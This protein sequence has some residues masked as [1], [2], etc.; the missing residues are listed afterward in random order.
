MTHRQR[1][2]LT[3]GRPVHPRKAESGATHSETIVV[4]GSSL[5]STPT[6]SLIPAL[7]LLMMY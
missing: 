5:E 6:V 3:V 1:P 7:G 2:A 4:Q